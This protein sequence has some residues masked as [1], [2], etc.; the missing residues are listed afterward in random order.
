[1]ASTLGRGTV[2]TMP[3]FEHDAPTGAASVHVV[4]GRAGRWIVRAGD[5][6]TIASI[7]PSAIEAERAARGV[8]RVRGAS[9]VVLHDRYCRFRVSHVA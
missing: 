1:M 3:M 9:R 2:H 4:P 8:A 7:H 5:E 6:A